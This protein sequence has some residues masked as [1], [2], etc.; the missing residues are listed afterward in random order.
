MKKFSNYAFWIAFVGALVVFLEDIESLFGIDINKMKNN[1]PVFFSTW[2]FCY[3][4]AIDLHEEEIEIAIE[5][6]LI[7]N[8]YYFYMFLIPILIYFERSIQEFLIY[9]Q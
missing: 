3:A 4:P 7:D 1:E 6:Y 9:N 2:G 8:R 5:K